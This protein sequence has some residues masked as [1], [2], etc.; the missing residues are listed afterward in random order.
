MIA[1]RQN[2]SNLDP[3][4]IA[5][6]VGGSQ[7]S[8]SSAFQKKARAELRRLAFDPNYAEGLNPKE[9][10]ENL[11]QVAKMLD[12]NSTVLLMPRVPV[13]ADG[14]HYLPL[15]W[16]EMSVS[17]VVKREKDCVRVTLGFQ[18]LPS[19]SM[20]EAHATVKNFRLG[21]SVSRSFSLTVKKGQTKVI[22]LKFP[23]STNVSAPAQ[24][25][26]RL[27]WNS[28]GRSGPI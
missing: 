13:G 26:Y 6:L 2:L 7:P 16:G 9:I 14:I 1:V 18:I 19:E 28:G 4:T 3:K 12:P 10:L 5:L 27:S 8:L 24:G 11:N 23:V 15:D 17:R 20:K 21:S 22:R 25:S